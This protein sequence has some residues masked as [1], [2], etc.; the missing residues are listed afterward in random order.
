MSEDPA[1]EARRVIEVFWSPDPP[2][3]PFPVDPVR[4]AKAMGLEVL[5]AVLESDVSGALVKEPGRDATILL[6]AGESK[7]RQRFTCAHEVG[8]YMLRRAGTDETPYSFVD[9]RDGLSAEGTDPDER[10][11]NAFAAELLMPEA[12]VKSWSGTYDDLE[13]AER[14][15][16]SSE[17]MNARLRSLQLAAV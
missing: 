5:E 16:V 1:V 9:K 6:A 11:A 8:H 14:F 3:T 2:D 10:W 15:G 12:T 13:M 17:A 4:V 7:R